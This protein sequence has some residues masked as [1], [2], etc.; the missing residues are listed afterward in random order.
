MDIYERLRQAYRNDRGIR[1]TA[2]E[3][4]DF[5]ESDDAMI[6]AIYQYVEEEDG[7]ELWENDQELR[8]KKLAKRGFGSRK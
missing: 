4:A 8:R 5:I 3:V 1:L 2:D 6:A 7:G